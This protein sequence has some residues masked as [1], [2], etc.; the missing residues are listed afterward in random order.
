VP[1]IADV[2]GMGNYLNLKRL[3]NDEYF[4]A[5]FLDLPGRIRTQSSIMPNPEEDPHVIVS[6]NDFEIFKK[7]NSEMIKRLGVGGL[8]H[9]LQPDETMAPSLKM[10]D[11][12]IAI[13]R[14]EILRSGLYMFRNKKNRT[15]VMRANIMTDDTVELNYDNPSHQSFGKL[16]FDPSK[17]TCVGPV[18][19]RILGSDK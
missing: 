18:V 1:S 10:N 2:L 6:P 17:L 14:P 11:Q 16:P 12:A 4:S 3:F 15:F 5:E 7:V 13:K 19:F 9:V 8:E